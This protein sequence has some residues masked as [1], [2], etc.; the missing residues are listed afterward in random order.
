MSEKL[1]E[2]SSVSMAPLF[3]EQRLTTGVFFH[4]T[5]QGNLVLGTVSGEL[6]GTHFRGRFLFATKGRWLTWHNLLE[7]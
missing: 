4:Q 5:F 2:G 7:Q 1:H 6:T 3:I